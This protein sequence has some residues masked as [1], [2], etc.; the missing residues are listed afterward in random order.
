MT[1]EKKNEN[2]SG[3][4]NKFN[5]QNKQTEERKAGDKVVENQPIV[6]P[7]TEKSAQTEAAPQ[8]K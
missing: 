2:T 6:E 5:E 3:K 4:P 8:K 1:D 7:T